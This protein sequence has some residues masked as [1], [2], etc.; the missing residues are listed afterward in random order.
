MIADGFIRQLYRHIAGPQSRLKKQSIQNDKLIQDISK[1]ETKLNEILKGDEKKLFLAYC[2]A[3]SELSSLVEQEILSWDSVLE[4]NFPLIP[5]AA[6]IH[7][8]RI[9]T[10]SKRYCIKFIYKRFCIMKTIFEEIGGRYTQVGDYQIPDLILP[11]KEESF[12]LGIWGKRHLR[13]IQQHQKVRFINLFTTDK[14]NTYLHEVDERAE[15][16]FFRVVNE[17]VRSE[18]ITEEL[19]VQN[20]LLWVQRMN[21][22][23]NRAEKIVNSE[24]I[25]A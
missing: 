19:K 16:L 20:Q 17:M 21:N 8:L 7:H 6:M 15:T 14:L 2:D 23:R 12:V 1:A 18:G 10:K 22:I 3:Y 11:E 5:F 25:F 9:P 4:R 13:Y 24:V